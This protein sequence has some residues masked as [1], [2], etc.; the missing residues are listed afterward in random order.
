[1]ILPKSENGSASARGGD[2][3][4]RFAVF[5][6]WLGVST[7]VFLLAFL[8]RYLDDLAR[9]RKG[10]FAERLIEEATGVY[11]AALLFL[12]VVKFGR[13]F[14]LTRENWRRRLPIH[15]FAA[16]AFSAI[17]TTIIAVSRKA[18]FSL[19]GM[20]EYDY[21]ILPIRYLME[22]ANYAL[23]YAMLVTLLHLFDHY[24][25]SRERELRT[26]HLEAQLAQTQLQALQ[27]QIHPH[28]L[29]NALNTISSVIY[30]DVQAADT[31]ITRL[32]D[33]LRHSLNASN[34][35]EVTLREELTFLN[36]YLDIMRPRF[37]ERLKVEFEVEEGINDALAP[38][39]ILQPLVENSIK[40]AAHP[41]SGAVRIA[42]RAARE[43]G[44]LRLEVED[45]GP[46]LATIQSA[47][48]NGLG[49]TN[50]AERLERLYGA[51]QEFT[52]RDADSGGLLVSVKLPYHTAATSKGQDG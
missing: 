17:H 31:M 29:F 11:S 36:L 47:S 28:F 12:L 22:F 48:T 25:A 13:R 24:R 7:V 30:E 16:A 40:H 49:L 3:R 41:T 8:Y 20:G 14:R 44:H 43:N 1:M 33:F 6:V 52:I 27:A 50:T 51:D 46:G 34:S 5:A 2:R 37:E 15:L 4:H 9:G 35:Q 19:A 42:V 45:D 18:I 32:S 10:T 21:G 38:K 26:A 23:W 39:L